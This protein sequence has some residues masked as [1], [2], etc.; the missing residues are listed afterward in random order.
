MTLWR[1]SNH[2]TLDG[3]GGLRASARWHTRGQRIVYASPNPATAL[4]E[5]LV[6]AEIDWRDVPVSFRFLEIAA[7]AG[8]Q[9]E[10]VERARLSSGWESRPE[11]TRRIGDEWLRSGRTAL[12]LVPCVIVPETYNILFNPL[13]RDAVEVAIVRMHRHA[14]DRRLAATGQ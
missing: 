5:I 12:L 11:S 13:H 1:I 4:L 8:I 3:R 9:S 6:H 7:P 14:F 10:T 2:P